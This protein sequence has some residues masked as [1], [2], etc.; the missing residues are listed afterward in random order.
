MAAAG[1]VPVVT[2]YCESHTNDVPFYAVAQLLRNGIGIQDLDAPADMLLGCLE[3]VEHP[4]GHAEGVDADRLPAGEP[5][6]TGE[7]EP[8]LDPRHRHAGCVG[9]DPELAQPLERAPLR[10]RVPEPGGE[11]VGL[12][13]LLQASA[14]LRNSIAA[15]ARYASQRSGSSSDAEAS[16][17]RNRRFASPSSMRRSL[18]GH[19]GIARR[20][21]P[22]GSLSSSVS[23]AARRFAASR[24]SA[25][26]ARSA[27]ASASAQRA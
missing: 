8:L 14:P 9:G 23:S 15:A 19:S 13:S 22:A 16:V 5:L 25:G 20:S 12:L 17:S 3:V 21:A 2:T 6:A 11:P 1:D 26:A 10:A 4:A 27:S 7:L 18:N 24:S